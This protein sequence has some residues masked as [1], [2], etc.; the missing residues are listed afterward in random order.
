MLDLFRSYWAAMERLEVSH[1]GAFGGS[2]CSLLNQQ[3]V[4]TPKLLHLRVRC[5]AA[6]CTVPRRCRQASTR[7]EAL[8]APAASPCC[9]GSC[10]MIPRCRTLCCPAGQ[11]EVVSANDLLGAPEAAPGG[12][13]L[14]ALFQRQP[15][16]GSASRAEVYALKDRA[17]VL[18]QLEAPPVV[19]HVAEA[20]RKKFPWEVGLPGAGRVL[21]LG[22]TRDGITRR[23]LGRGMTGRRARGAF[24][25]T[26][27]MAAFWHPAWV[28]RF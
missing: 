13:S 12:M 27:C 7:A 10:R 11:E 16:A 21:P 26:A 8:P 15:A 20:E 17:G 14:G 18:A 24:F 19:L 3:T 25:A 23:Q 2:P 1:G 22:R 4:D 5:V 9:S 28:A 6:S